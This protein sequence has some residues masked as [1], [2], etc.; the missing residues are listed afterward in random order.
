MNRNE[1]I[2]LKLRLIHNQIHKIMEAK[3]RANEGEGLTS[4]QRWTLGFLKDHEG[5]DIYQ[6]DIEAEFSVSRAT[7]SNMLQLMERKGLIGR[8]AVEHDAR[9]KKVVLTERAS[10][11]MDQA[12]L[13]IKNMEARLT[14]GMTEEDIRQLQTYLNLMMQNLGVEDEGEATRCCGKIDE[15]HKI[16]K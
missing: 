2:G 12:H 10:R 1:T 16:K 5:E 11:M 14:Q 15:Q 9:L 6:R 7:A 3:R 4:M 13:D 8:V